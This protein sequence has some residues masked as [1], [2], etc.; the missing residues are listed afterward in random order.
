[1]NLAAGNTVA[2]VHNTNTLN[3][4]SGGSAGIGTLDTTPTGAA[5]S[6]KVTLNTNANAIAFGGNITGAGGIEKTGAG[7]LTLTGAN[8][9]SG[10]TTVTTGILAGNIAANTDLTVAGSATYDGTGAA[11]T[12][13]A[14]DGA[15]GSSIINTHGLSAQSGIFSGVISGAGGLTKTGTVTDTLI[16]SDANTYTGMTT[17]Q[18]GTL[19]LAATASLASHDLTLH[20]GATFQVISG[21]THSLDNGSLTV[22]GENAT[23]DGDLSAQNATL[24]FI[25]PASVSQPLLTVTGTADITGSAVNVGV[26]GGTALPKGTQLTLIQTAPGDLTANNLT[27]GSGIVEAGVTA[28]YGL[29]LEVDPLTGL[30][31]GTVTTGGAAE[32]AKA[33]SEG[34]LGGAVLVNQGADLI[35][36]PGMSEAAGA[37]RRPGRGSFGTLSGGSL[38]HDTGSHVDMHS[39]SLMAGLSYGAELEP[40]H[41][42]L[43]AFFEYGNGSYD[44]YNHFSNAASVHGDGDIDHVG[45]GLLGRMDFSNTGPGHFHAEASLRAGRV[46]NEYSSADLRDATGRKADYDSS[47]A[48]YGLHFGA[49]YLWKITDK[50]T[51]DLSGKYFWTRQAG[52]SVR[53]STGDEV[54]FKDVDSSRLRLGVRYAH[55]VNEYLLSPYVG[56]AYEHEFDG[57]ARAST[58]GFPIDAPSLRGD[59]G[60]GTLGLTL[61]PSPGLP[62]SF[63]LGIQGYVGKRE[64]VT[65][66]LRARWEF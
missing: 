25:A 42:V 39:L 38:R 21:G 11:R 19:V 16:L 64:G 66:S 14:L 47:S 50:A 10:G 15:T 26:S 48:Y 53:L 6:P 24:N 12:V 62:L 3:F 61:K 37:A 17:V 46:R 44:T 32:R 59:T 65:G 30:L 57:K 55:A 58:N 35:A 49:G 18:G 9:Y 33:L 23:Y 51:L 31:Q 27:Q 4:T 36:G 34:F 40:G 29:A 20:G 5:L 43:G 22:R 1:L 54:R 2:S 63:D 45:G 7:T 28:I 52:D 13:N 41:L 60:I 8:N 56:V